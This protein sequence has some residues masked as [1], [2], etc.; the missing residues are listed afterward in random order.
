[1]DA[2]ELLIADSNEDFRL[3][4][5]QVLGDRYRVR[6]CGTGKEA[7]DILRGEHCDVLVLD[8]MLP[9]LDGVGLLQT[10]V[11][12]GIC[13]MTMVVTRFVNEYVLETMSQLGVGY[14]I[15]KPCEAAAAAARVLELR[16]GIHPPAP[17]HDPRV[18]VS[19]LL[20]S[21]GVATRHDGYTYLREAILLMAGDPCQTATKELYPKVAAMFGCR[22]EQVERCIRNALIIAWNRRDQRVWQQFFPAGNERPTNMEFITCLAE[23]LYLNRETGTVC[24][25]IYR[26]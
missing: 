11:E 9:E 26:L 23:S 1:M 24:Q 25:L 22:G 15:R 3:A 19:G 2:P 10:I 4:L 5:A 7:L 13:P 8:L 6:C 16:C 12:E 14:L 20:H 21:L 17:M 18:F